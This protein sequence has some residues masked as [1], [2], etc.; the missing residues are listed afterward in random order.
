MKA[1]AALRREAVTSLDTVVRVDSSLSDEPKRHLISLLVEAGLPKQAASV[2][3]CHSEF[4]V[5]NCGKGHRFNPVPTYHCH[6]RL[7][8]D[9][10]RDRQ[11]RAFSRLMPVLRAHQRR[12]RFDRP[13]LIT[14]TGR[15]SFDPL[16]VQD[17]RYKAWFAKLRR[18]TVWQHCI[19]GAVAAFEFTWD[20][21]KGWHYHIHILAFRKV[22]LD[23]AEL[24]NLWQR[25]TAGVGE[26]V[27][28][29]SKGSLQSMTEETLKYCF[30]PTDLGLKG[31]PEKRWGVEQILEF[32]E[33]RRVKLSESYGSLRGFKFDEDD[34]LAE[35]E[36]APPPHEHAHLVFGSPCPDCGAPLQ[37]E[38]VPRSV[39]RSLYD[40][41]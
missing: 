5:L 23:Q 11:R 20:R 34:L 33:L 15:S 13:V 21:E 2:Q 19:R 38:R 14:L 31:L 1:A 7:C 9:C 25:I 40:S 4:R 6:Y 18:T 39:A 37:F 26:V 3:H 8:V 28:I 32:N 29:Q 12:H 10:A 17:K 16:I 30:K 27:D 41:T 24:S 22:W 35:A 36:N